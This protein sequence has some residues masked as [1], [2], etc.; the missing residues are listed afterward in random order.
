[1]YKRQG[2]FNIYRFLKET[3]FAH[4]PIWLRDRLQGTDDV[5]AV[6]TAIGIAKG[7]PLCEETVRL[8]VSIYGAEAGNLALKTYAIGGVYLGGGIVPKMFEAFQ[9]NGFLDLFFRK[10]RYTEMMKEIPVRV[11]LNSNAPLIGAAHYAA[12]MD[13]HHQPSS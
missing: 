11:I 3:G 13:R 4:E 2:L 12:E 10:G 8:F 7:D 6:I 1:M 9:Q 5:S